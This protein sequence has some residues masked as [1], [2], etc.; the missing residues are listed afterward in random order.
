VLSLSNL[1]SGL[2]ETSPLRYIVY[3]ALIRLAA[4]TNLIHVVNPK[5]DE[6]RRWLTVWDV[7]TAKAQALLRGLYEAYT[8]CKHRS[9][10]FY[11]P[12]VCSS[13]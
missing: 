13:F 2:D 12:F 1:F 6:L 10:L 9:S 11:I 8:E 7:G 4:Q 5:L 3:M